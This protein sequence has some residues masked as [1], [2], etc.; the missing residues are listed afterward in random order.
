[1][2]LLKFKGNALEL[3]VDTKAYPDCEPPIKQA[4]TLIKAGKKVRVEIRGVPSKIQFQYDR[5]VR[6]CRSDETLGTTQK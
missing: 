5:F 2:G 6:S 4:E 1:M 3:S